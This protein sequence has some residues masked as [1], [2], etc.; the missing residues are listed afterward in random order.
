MRMKQL[1]PV[2]AA[3]VVAVLCVATVG[4]APPPPGKT[5]PK[6][7]AQ[8]ALAVK[9]A[10]A[11]QVLSEIASIDEELNVVSEQFDGARYKLQVLRKRLAKEQVQLGAAKVRYARAVLFNETLTT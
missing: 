10:E 8:K 1:I 3:A 2:V 9:E 4:A 7:K 11:R 6:T 5:P